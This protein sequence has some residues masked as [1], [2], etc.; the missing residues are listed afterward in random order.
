MPA[1]EITLRD[2]IS[3]HT[4]LGPVIEPSGMGPFIE[5]SG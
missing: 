1:V 3:V 5:P 4:S 2:A